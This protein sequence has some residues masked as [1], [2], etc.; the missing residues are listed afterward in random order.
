MTLLFPQ[1]SKPEKLTK[2]RQ[3]EHQPGQ[4]ASDQ[5]KAQKAWLTIQDKISHYLDKAIIHDFVRSARVTFAPKHIIIEVC[6]ANHYEEFVDRA[7]PGL[8]RAKS[9]LSFEDIHFRI[10]IRPRTTGPRAAISSRTVVLPT[11]SQE[12]SASHSSQTA[13]SNTLNSSYTFD[14]FVKGP[15]NQ[16]A[17]ATC[18]S[19]AESPG[20]NYNPLFIYGHSGLG[21]THLLHAVGGKIAAIHDHLHVLHT[22]THNFMN[23]LIHCIRHGQQARFKEKY[24]RCDVL[25]VDDIQFISG[26]KATQEEFFHV[27]NAL[28][29][30]K[31]QIIITSDKYPNEISD[32]EDRLR[33]RFEW[34]LISDIQPPDTEHRMAILYSK[35]EDMK[36]N[37]PA[38][39]IAYIASRCRRNVRELEGALRR[40]VAFAGF[41]AHTI[42]LDLAVSAFQHL[43]NHQQNKVSIDLIQKTVAKHY[44]IKAC[45]LRSAKRH[46]V[47]S[48]PR[49]VAFYLS[50][51]LTSHSLPEIG[52]AFGG[53]DHTTV[54]YGVKKIA[55]SCKTDAKL[56]FHVDQITSTII[57]LSQ[58]V[59]C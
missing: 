18:Q 3:P 19:V 13:T 27:F 46:R 25:L 23:E 38:D 37:V 4:A 31:Q 34:G 56:R 42:N 29:E 35:A 52:A 28:Y 40:L 30:R 33:N 6:D 16:F 9:H 45:D 54:L 44:D 39:V 32:I 58:Q 50:K 1:P 15:S 24:T 57:S 49:Q 14:N 12:S 21:K 10:T 43:N 20:T 26:K 7:L 11:A 36:V 2:L 47:V 48:L 59:S 51:E 41:H 17:Y 55:A 8:K 22:T 5:L 53:K